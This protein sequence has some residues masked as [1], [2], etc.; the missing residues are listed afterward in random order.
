[1]FLFGLFWI[2]AF[3]VALEQFIV[4]A[5][6][7]MWY[8]SGDG[9]DVAIS[10]G[11]VGV[12]IATKWAFRYHL[13]SLA[14][15]S[16]LI[17]VVQ[18]IKVVFEYFASKE[19]YLKTKDNFAVKA[20]LCC[21]RYCIWCL[22]AYVKFINKNSYI[23]IALHNSTFCTACKESFYLIVRHIGRFS[24]LGVIGFLITFLGKGIIVGLSV[25]VSILIMNSQYPEIQ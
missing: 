14:I 2:I 1:M 11:D 10:F 9:S 25:W 6:C 21:I 20:I 24:S 16:F 23:Q 3:I 18:M 15:G 5:T 4:A 7:C 13:G 8:F 12:G 17:A 22:D 19:D